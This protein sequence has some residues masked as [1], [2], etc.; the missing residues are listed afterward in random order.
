MLKINWGL[1][2]WEI[3][4]ASLPTLC[5]SVLLR[6]LL[7]GMTQPSGMPSTEVFQLV[8][9]TSSP[10]L[11][12]QT[13]YWVSVTLLS[14]LTPAI[15]SERSSASGRPWIPLRVARIPLQVPRIPLQVPRTPLRVAQ[16]PLRAAQTH[17]MSTP[18][19][20]PRPPAGTPTIP[21]RTPKILHPTPS[22][23]PFPVHLY[24]PLLPAPFHLLRTPSFLSRHLRTPRI[25]LPVLYRPPT[26][27]PTVFLTSL[28]SS[29]P[30]ADSTQLSEAIA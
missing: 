7:I 8:S 5:A 4:I 14:G 15:G 28:P 27:T 13:P 6:P 18:I 16:I 9:R 12:V 11:T 25:P 30:M 21:G 3:L 26:G 24:H 2:I 19:V 17:F 23:I 22:P 1:S 10:T 20:L 29:M